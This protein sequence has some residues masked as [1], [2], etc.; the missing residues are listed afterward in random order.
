MAEVVGTADFYTIP[1]L[2]TDRQTDRQTDS[3]CSSFHGRGLAEF[4]LVTS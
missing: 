2:A 4:A 1:V 3:G